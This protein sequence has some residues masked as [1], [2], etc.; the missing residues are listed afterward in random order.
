MPITAT[1]EMLKQALAPQ[2]RVVRAG[3]D[4]RKFSL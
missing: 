4:L 2:R 3:G 1:L